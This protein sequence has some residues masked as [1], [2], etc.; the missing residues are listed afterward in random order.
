MMLQTFTLLSAKLH[1]KREE[2]DAVGGVV[3][4]DFTVNQNPD[5]Q[6]GDLLV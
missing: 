1:V 4:I 6:N 5:L 3:E 2:K